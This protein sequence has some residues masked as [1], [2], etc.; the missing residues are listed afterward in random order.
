MTFASISGQLITS[1]ILIVIGVWLLWFWPRS[2]RRK[3]DSGDISEEAGE[4]ALRKIQPGQ[5][6]IIIII[7]IVL[8]FMKLWKAGFFGYSKLLALIPATLS[9]GLFI[10]WLRHRRR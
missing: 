7:A 8:M 6:Y 4:N 3:I 9:V 2:I 5:G 10:L 1:L